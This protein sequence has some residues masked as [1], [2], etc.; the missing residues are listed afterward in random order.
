M[1]CGG[2]KAGGRGGLA[3]AP[4][5]AGGGRARWGRMQTAQGVARVAARLGA[6]S[7][8]TAGGHACTSVA[9]ARRTQGASLVILWLM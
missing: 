9:A 2:G 3:R 1:E 7:A 6:V 4:G 5:D 8:T